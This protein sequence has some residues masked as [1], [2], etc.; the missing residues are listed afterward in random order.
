MFSLNTYTNITG[1]NNRLFHFKSNIICHPGKHSSDSWVLNVLY[2]QG[3]YKE[4]H[5][6]ITEYADLKPWLQW[7][8]VCFI[9]LNTELTTWWRGSGKDPPVPRRSPSATRQQSSVCP[10]GMNTVA[11]WSC[12]SVSPC[13]ARIFGWPDVSLL[14]SV[15]NLLRLLSACLP[16]SLCQPFI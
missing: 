6:C 13:V 1:I 11:K 5:R 3:L 7:A 10:S 15:V 16:A 4:K 8:L 9:Q 14:L 2:L 12:S